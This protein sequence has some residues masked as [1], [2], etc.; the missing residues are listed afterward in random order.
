[1]VGNGYT[2]YRNIDGDWD[3]HIHSYYLERS[4]TSASA[5]LFKGGMWNFVVSSLFHCAQTQMFTIDCYANAAS[6]GKAHKI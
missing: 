2:L 3:P 6:N 5:A 4:A 1:M